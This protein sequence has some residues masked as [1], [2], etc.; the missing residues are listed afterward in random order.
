MLIT[1]W[2]PVGVRSQ[3]DIQGLAEPLAQG[4]RDHGITIKIE[5]CGEKLSPA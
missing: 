2:D 5:N 1:M 4:E 3:R